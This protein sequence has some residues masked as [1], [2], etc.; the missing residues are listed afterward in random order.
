MLSAENKRNYLL[1]VRSNIKIYK[2]IVILKNFWNAY[3]WITKYNE[4]QNKYIEYLDIPDI[5]HT[6][7][8]ESLYKY[9]SGI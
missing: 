9:Y 6:S 7:F 4:L 1:S 3:I 5:D 8:A 2:I